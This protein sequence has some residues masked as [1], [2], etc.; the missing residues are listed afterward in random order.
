MNDLWT[1][2]TVRGLPLAVSGEVGRAE[3]SKEG[4]TGTPVIE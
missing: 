1:W 3:E 4:K 2:R